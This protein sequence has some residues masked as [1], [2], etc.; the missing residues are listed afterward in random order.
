[1]G[2]LIKGINEKLDEVYYDDNVAVC[3]DCGED[4]ELNDKSSFTIL[5]DAYYGKIISKDTYDKFP[6]NW[7]IL[8]NE[9]FK[10]VIKNEKKKY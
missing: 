6:S 2:F 4:I 9:C 3:D 5:E 10:E 7:V 1:M 8:C